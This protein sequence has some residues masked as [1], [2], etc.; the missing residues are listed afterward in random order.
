[1]FDVESRLVAI[2]PT[3][4]PLLELKP[5]AYLLVALYYAFLRNFETPK[6]TLLTWRLVVRHTSLVDAK[7]QQ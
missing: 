1:M 7:H 3:L 2:A 5:G 6:T 4:L